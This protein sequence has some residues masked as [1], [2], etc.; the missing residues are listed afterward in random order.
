[1][2]VQ[3]IK[4]SLGE[5]DI[6][7]LESSLENA[8]IYL[9]ALLDMEQNEGYRN[10]QLELTHNEYD[11]SLRLSLVGYRDETEK[12]ALAREKRDSKKAQRDIAIRTRDTEKRRKQYKKPKKEFES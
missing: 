5:L 7:V 12:E 2:P 11:N 3:Q 10:L 6:Y 9:E 1:M 8:I 4:K